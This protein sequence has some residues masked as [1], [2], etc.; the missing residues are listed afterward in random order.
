MTIQARPLA[1]KIILLTWMSGSSPNMTQMIYL[2][3]QGH[4]AHAV[5]SYPQSTNSKRSDQ[6]APVWR[7]SASLPTRGIVPETNIVGP[8]A[9]IILP[10]VPRVE[11]H[12]AHRPRPAEIMTG[13]WTPKN[14]ANS[15]VINSP[16]AIPSQPRPIS[17]SM[18]TV[19]LKNASATR[20]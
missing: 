18:T 5:L 15:K 4:K 7:A 6:T 10:A 17:V 11:A 14:A 13:N 12:P 19:I 8:T 2:T 3:Q 16:N 20:I 1:V 9:R